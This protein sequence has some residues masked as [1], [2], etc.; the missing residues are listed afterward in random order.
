MNDLKVE[1]VDSYVNNYITSF[2][3]GFT[4]TE[5]QI[6]LHTHNN[7]N[8]K[9]FWKA[10]LGNTLGSSPNGIPLYYPGDV[11]TAIKC[12]IDNRNITQEEWD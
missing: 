2:E 7:I 10:M 1:D 11:I 3:L 4:Q 12:G 5:L 6:I 8:E 9:A